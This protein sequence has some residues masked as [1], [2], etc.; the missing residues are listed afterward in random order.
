V[1]QRVDA[2][3][4]SHG[5][6]LVALRTHAAVA[7]GGLAVGVLAKLADLSTVTWLADIASFLG[8]W[9][10]VVALASW[11]SRRPVRAASGSATFFV[12]LTLGYYGW[13]RLVLGYGAS[14]AFL[15]WLF[16]SVTAVPALAA[17]GCWTRGRGGFLAGVVAAGAAALVVLDGVLPQLVLAFRG[18]LPEGF[19]LRY[20][21]AVV[22]V[23]SGGV[24]LALLATDRRARVTGLLS[25][26]PAACVVHLCA[27]LFS[28][29]F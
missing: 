26:V 22:D 5:P 16:L 4:S 17:L 14:A 9:V 3:S 2:T 13:A 6:S 15:G 24:V 23:V 19:P 18:L 20:V 21:Q 25:V 27:S 29:Y 12:A 10:L 28:S 7:A 11:S 1:V 8:V